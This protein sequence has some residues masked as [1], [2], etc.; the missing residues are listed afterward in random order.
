MGVNTQVIAEGNACEGVSLSSS[1]FQSI[2]QGKV[3]KPCLGFFLFVKKQLSPII[4][5][6]INLNSTKMNVLKKRKATVLSLAMMM[7]MM[8]PM[9]A[10]AQEGLFNRSVS[11]EAYY[12]FGGSKSNTGLMG[13][14][15]T[16][17]GVINNQIFASPCRWVAD[18]LSCLPLG[19]AMR[20]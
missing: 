10:S 17:T 2:V 19:L 7:A 20:P 9:G 1:V 13:D 15:G 4:N 5:L 14:R 12:S 6:F 3:S 8:L 18:W 11:D 16:A